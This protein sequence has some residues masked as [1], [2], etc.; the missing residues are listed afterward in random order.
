MQQCQ[1]GQTNGR[2]PRACGNATVIVARW[3]DQGGKPDRTRSGSESSSSGLQ[4]S[5]S[6]LFRKLRCSLTAGDKILEFEG[7]S[8]LCN[9]ESL[10]KCVRKYATCS[11]AV[12]S[13]QVESTSANTCGT[14]KPALHSRPCQLIRHFTDA[15]CHIVPHLIDRIG[16]FQCSRKP[17]F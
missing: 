6:C 15:A 3:E 16:V 13:L 2:A 14:A 8:L 10:S 7:S 1:A 11:L 4:S 9:K 12:S 5:I 17:Q